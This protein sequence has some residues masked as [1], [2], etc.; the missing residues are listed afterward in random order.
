MVG[1][2]P[3]PSAPY[4]IVQDGS[5]TPLPVNTPAP[6]MGQHNEAVLGGLLGLSAEDLDALARD[7]I[8]G[9]KPRMP[10]RK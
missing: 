2:Q 3:N 5:A 6:T 4:R 1:R 8:I 10:T 9:H 7:G